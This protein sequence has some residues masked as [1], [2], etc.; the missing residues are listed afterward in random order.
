M[1]AVMLGRSPIPV[2]CHVLLELTED[3]TT[4]IM[5]FSPLEQTTDSS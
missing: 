2:N 1:V 4:E 5:P 3:E